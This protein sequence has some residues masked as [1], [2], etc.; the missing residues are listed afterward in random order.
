MQNVLNLESLQKIPNIIESICNWNA[1]RYEQ[2]YS[3]KLTLDLLDEEIE[4]A[5]FAADKGDDIEACDGFGDTFYVAIG[6]LW[7]M[8]YTAEKIGEMLD[9]TEDFFSTA[10][11]P[12]TATMH[13]FKRYPNNPNILSLVAYAAFEDLKHYVGGH[14]QAALDIIRAICLSN[15]TKPVVKTAT[16]VKANTDKGAKFIAPTE[17]IETIISHVQKGVYKH[18]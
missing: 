10:P 7:K 17:A 6:G 12:T 8:G 18:A 14:D 9:A 1:K 4:E 13:W 3:T 5:L 16:D 15:D 2:E 11:P